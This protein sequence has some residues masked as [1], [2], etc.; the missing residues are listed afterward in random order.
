MGVNE[1]VQGREELP[2]LLKVD[3]A[4]EREQ[5]ERLCAWR[6]RRGAD[7]CRTALAAVRRAAAATDNLL[8][9]IVDAVRAGATVGEVSDE[10]RA[11]F[12]EHRE[13]EDALGGCG[14]TASASVS[15]PR[16]G[17]RAAGAP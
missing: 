7:A 12:G 16:T 3:P 8:P 2:P 10:L 9:P 5:V 17:P 4:K 1:F 6:A 14:L 11:V 13:I 15:S